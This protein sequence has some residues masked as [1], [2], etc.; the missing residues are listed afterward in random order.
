MNCVRS[1]GKAETLFVCHALYWA[2]RDEDRIRPDSVLL[3]RQH[4]LHI[5]RDQIDFEVD[6]AA[7]A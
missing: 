7:R 4:P 3:C 5:T 6:Q 2:T 1:T